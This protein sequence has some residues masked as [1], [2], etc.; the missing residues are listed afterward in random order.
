MNGGVKKKFWP[1]LFCPFFCALTHCGVEENGQRPDHGLDISR[2]SLW[3][4]LNVDA[5]CETPPGETSPLPKTQ[6]KRLNE[7]LVSKASLFV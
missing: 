2:E 6:Q 7:C 4:P 3:L 1:F 5:D